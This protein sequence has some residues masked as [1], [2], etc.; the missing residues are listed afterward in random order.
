MR[1]YLNTGFP[2]K[3]AR[4]S[5]LKNIPDLLR[6]DMEGKIVD[7]STLYM[8]AI[9]RLLWETLY[10]FVY[11]TYSVYYNRCTGLCSS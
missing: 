4:F 7:I 8:L 2:I 5:K 1:E 10:S 6:N 9:W 3:D 11:C